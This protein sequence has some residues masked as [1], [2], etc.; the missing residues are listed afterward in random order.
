MGQVSAG[1]V[2]PLYKIT[3]EFRI[4]RGTSIC[5]SE[6]NHHSESPNYNS[7]SLPR[8]GGGGRHR[9]A[10]VKEPN[11]KCQK[12]GQQQNPFILKAVVT[13]YGFQKERINNLSCKWLEVNTTEHFIISCDKYTWESWELQ[14]Y[15]ISK[16]KTSSIKECLQVRS[17][18]YLQSLIREFISRCHHE[19]HEK[20]T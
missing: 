11:T 3:K 1:L 2:A 17:I 9:F 15:F 6:K 16:Y 13:T 14:E 4:T 19:N 10:I 7:G 20:T 8:G 12:Q 5:T 18:Q